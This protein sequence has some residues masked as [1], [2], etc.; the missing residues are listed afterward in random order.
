[1]RITGNPG[2]Y[3]IHAYVGGG[4]PNPEPVESGGSN[5]TG[6]SGGSSGWSMYAES[7][8]NEESNSNE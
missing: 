2:H 1:M 3:H 6:T 5:R 8:D 4:P 7:N